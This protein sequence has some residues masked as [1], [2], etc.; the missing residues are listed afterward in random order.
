MYYPTMPELLTMGPIL[1][2]SFS[3]RHTS[4]EWKRIFI[5][6][7]DNCQIGYVNY[8]NGV[9]YN[10]HSYKK[11][12]IAYDIDETDEIFCRLIW[13]L[14]TGEELP[15]YPGLVARVTAEAAADKA[16]KL[17]ARALLP[18]RKGRSKI[19]GRQPR[20]LLFEVV[21]GRRP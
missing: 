7:S 2:C 10:W 14:R 3:V 13:W 1:R 20:H 12:W 6:R 19:T 17:A 18:F 4:V 8:H 5:K 15:D 21:N 16:E 9:L 11:D